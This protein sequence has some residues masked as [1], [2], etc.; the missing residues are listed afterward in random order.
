M[1]INNER[2]YSQGICFNQE[3]G[4]FC[5]ELLTSAVIFYIV[6]SGIFFETTFLSFFLIA[7]PAALL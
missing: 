5:K 1:Y 7:Y 4:N 3:V 6:V 2:Y